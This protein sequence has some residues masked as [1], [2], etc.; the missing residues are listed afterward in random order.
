M[1][2]TGHG[3]EVAFPRDGAAS[4]ALETRAV[5]TVRDL[6]NIVRIKDDGEAGICIAD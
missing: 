6:T 4:A 5:A 3:G 2:L 1:T